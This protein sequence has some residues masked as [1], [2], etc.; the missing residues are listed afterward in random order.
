M[1]PL[2][3]AALLGVSVSALAGQITHAQTAAPIPTQESEAALVADGAT[4]ADE[5]DDVVV[6]GTRTTGRTRL[7]SVSP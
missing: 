2:R 5:G 1:H 7:D 3:F 6:T 4:V